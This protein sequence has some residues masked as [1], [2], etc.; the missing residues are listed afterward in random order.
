MSR[1]S[2]KVR[3]SFAVSIAA[4]AFGL[5]P[6]DRQARGQHEALLAAGDGDIDA[7]AVHAKASRR[8]S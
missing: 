5:M 3:G 6:Q 8:S 1:K 2:K 7:P 4:I